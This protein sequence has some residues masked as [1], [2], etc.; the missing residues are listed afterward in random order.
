MNNR[1]GKER[2]ISKELLEFDSYLDIENNIKE[3][4]ESRMSWIRSCYKWF[5]E[6]GS[7]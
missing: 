4:G 1:D 7:S 2:D 3:K 6:A 5:T